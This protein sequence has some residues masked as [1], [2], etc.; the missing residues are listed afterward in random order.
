MLRG[1]VLAFLVRRLLLGTVVVAAVSFLS[2]AIFAT[3]ASPLW[4]FYANPNSPQALEV[5]KRA[6]LHD[7][8][9]TRYWLW[10]EGLFTGQG[11]GHTAIADVPV[12]SVVWPALWITVELIGVSLVLV[13]VLSVLLGALGARRRRSPLAAGLRTVSYVVWSVP[14]FLLAEL[15]LQGVVRVGPAWHL[16]LALGGPPTPGLGWS[17]HAVGDWLSHM[18]LPILVVTAGLVAV[19]SRYVRSGMLG[20]LGAPYTT[21]ARAKGLPERRVVLRHALRNSL[22]PFIAALSLDFGAVITASLAVDW[23]FQ[24]HGLA[25]VFLGQVVSASDPFVIQ[26]ELVIV[27]VIVVV[28]NLLGDLAGAWLDPRA[29]L[30]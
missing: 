8:L 19:Y 5:A 10:V 25:S 24:L 16:H 21:V 4:V 18:T 30:V 11:F 26:A 9:L 1:G 13:V 28:A 17:L 6:H 22:G 15:A 20:A 23:V 3:A 27:A 14:A 7:P 29:R 12:G 2:W